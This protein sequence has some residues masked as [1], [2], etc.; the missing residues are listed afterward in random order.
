MN[1]A[2]NL[3]FC[4][5][6]NIGDGL[7]FSLLSLR[8]HFKGEMDVYVLTADPCEEF[9][10]LIRRLDRKVRE[11]NR[12]SRV[13]LFDCSAQFN[14]NPPSANMGTR[15]TPSCMLRLYADLVPGLPDRVLYLDYD[16]VCH[17]D[18]SEY[19]N[20][21]IDD[22]DYVAT[23]DYYGAWFY[24]PFK[25]DYCNSGVLLMNLRNM[26]DSGL[27]ERCRE[28][29][30]TRKAF[31]PDQ[32]AL[33]FCEPLRRIVPSIFNDQRRHHTDTLF[34]HYSTTWRVFP[35]PHTVGVKP[36]EQERMHR[37]LDDHSCDS[38]YEEFILFKNNLL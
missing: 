13:R 33:N 16:V 34:R 1:S 3:L 8:A 19:Y 32:H 2:L 31:L 14:A 26:K 36:W 30:R 15:F 35:Y 29:C 25:H 4:G 23:L 11:S 17:A 21:P 5:D 22:I 20:Q 10:D 18:P 12:G 38:I 27:L 24:T 7:A 9:S 37:Q 6:R 28:Y